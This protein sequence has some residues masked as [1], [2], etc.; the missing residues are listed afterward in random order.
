M[1]HPPIPPLNK[2]LFLLFPKKRGSPPLADTQCSLPAT[3]LRPPPL[4]QNQKFPRV[5]GFP[6]LSRNDPLLFPPKSVKVPPPPK[7]KNF[8]P[9]S[10]TYPFLFPFFSPR[11][12]GLFSFLPPLKGGTS[13]TFDYFFPVPFFFFTFS[14]FPPPPLGIN[15]FFFFFL[16]KYE[17]CTSKQ[18]GLPLRKVNL[19]LVRSFL[20][21]SSRKPLPS[22]LPHCPPPLSR[23]FSLFRHPFFFC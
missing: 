23:P 3:R 17:G 2:K 7:G 18:L 6:P 8:F 16:L 9:S 22:R 5:G 15:S 11:S 4:R 13:R 14:F 12:W 10:R 20:G 1:K 19:P 21:H